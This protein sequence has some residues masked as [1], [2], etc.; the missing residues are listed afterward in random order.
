MVLGNKTEAE[1]EYRKSTVVFESLLKSEPDNREYGS[2][3]NNIYYNLACLS[4]L[5]IGKEPM[6]IQEHGDRA[7]LL[8]QQAIAAG[9]NDAAHIEKDSDFD[10][11]R[12]RPDFKKL[13][14]DLKK[15][16]KR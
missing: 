9:Y 13:L 6:K 11:I 15:G 4:S 10:A 16:S 1:V 7:V 14:A 2:I 3:L 12:D 5:A 8:L